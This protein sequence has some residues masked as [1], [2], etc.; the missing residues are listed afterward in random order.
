MVK[1]PIGSTPKVQ[2]FA[3]YYSTLTYAICSSSCRILT[4]VTTQM[5]IN[6][7][8]MNFHVI[9]QVKKIQEFDVIQFYL[10]HLQLP[11]ASTDTT[12]ILKQK[13]LNEK[14]T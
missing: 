5:K 2:Y 7:Q 12:V 14:S 8:Q 4:V 6:H 3:R 9:I 10:N 11:N 13:I 1:N